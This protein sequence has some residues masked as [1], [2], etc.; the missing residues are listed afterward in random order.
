MVTTTIPCVE[1]DRISPLQDF[2]EVIDVREGEGKYILILKL[3]IIKFGVWRS[4]L[5]SAPACR[6]VGSRFVSRP[7]TLRGLALR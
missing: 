1:I 7:G 4:S 3:G 6:K 2:S 5:V